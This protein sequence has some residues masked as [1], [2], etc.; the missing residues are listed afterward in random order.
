MVQPIVVNEGP[1]PWLRWLAL[2]AAILVIVLVALAVDSES[3]DEYSQRVQNAERFEQRFDDESSER[4][5]FRT[6]DGDVV[7]LSVDEEGSIAQDRDGDFEG[8]IFGPSEDGEFAGLIVND[9]GSF[10]AYRPG[11]DIAGKTRIVPTADG[12][13]ELLSPNGDSIRISLG[14]NGIE[15]RDQDGNSVEL[16]R[17]ADGRI[18]LGDGLRVNESDLQFDP[19]RQ[20]DPDIGSGPRFGFGGAQNLIILVLGVLGVVAAGWWF[21][22]MKPKYRLAENAVVPPTPMQTGP[23]TSPAADPW[24]EFEAYLQELRANPDPTQA[25]RLAFAYAEQGV[26]S[27]A[28]REFEQ[29]PY[30]WCAVVGESSPDLAAT[31]G[32]LADSYSSIR[33][34]DEGITSEERDVCVERLRDLVYRA[35]Q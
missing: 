10:S 20:F 34:A 24:A 1:P 31:L 7:E 4:L 27:L 29:T 28:S 19:S 35:C 5:F 22:A 30:E 14:P 16:P 21:F 11:D 9:D 12:G 3:R 6:P 25:V 13:F 23:T 17:D 18:N 33:F 2:P 26:G 32:S 8:L 15:G